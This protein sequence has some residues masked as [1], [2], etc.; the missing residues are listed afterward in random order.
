MRMTKSTE[1]YRGAFLQKKE[2]GTEKV[3]S[4][5]GLKRA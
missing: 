4:E 5:L 1:I 3:V 2:K